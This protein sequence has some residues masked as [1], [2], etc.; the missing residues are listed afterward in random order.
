MKLTLTSSPHLHRTRTTA[1]LMRLV[2]YA[3]LPGLLLQWW[4]FGWG[5]LI[6]LA[7]CATTA[8]VCEA[9]VLQLRKR[10]FE[11]A[12]SDCSA[13]L[14]AMLLA[15]SLPPLAPWWV[16]VVGSF[17]AIVMVKQ[18]YGG[19]GFNLFN[20]A[21]AAYV[22]LL[23]AFPLNMTAWLPPKELAQIIPGFIDSLYVVFSGYTQQGFSLEQIRQG[24][25]GITMATPLDG[26]KHQMAQGLTYDESLAALPI[27]DGGYGS[28]WL[29]IN[30]AYLLGG[31]YLLR[32]SAINWH[33]PLGVLIGL[34]VPS[35]LCSL[36]IGDQVASFN[37]HLLSGGFMLG[38]FFIATDPV[39][40]ATSDKGRLYYGAGIGLLIYL[41]RTWGGY[42]DAI[43]FAVLLMNMTVPLL[44]HYTQPRTY[45]HGS[46][47]K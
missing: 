21:M 2:I 5:V 42:P 31:L 20:P 1:Q 36:F 19:M 41:V 9:S 8:V 47:K 32:I 44:D 24:V 16:A 15:L 13:L 10:D 37:F 18:L 7:L 17:F 23:I 45:G 30:L 11:S 22:M 26:V 33:I 28:G 6:Q 4:F 46:D 3:A 38:V 25:D 43:A 29:W 35:L 39:S 34:A 40:A 12:L 14:T 27:T